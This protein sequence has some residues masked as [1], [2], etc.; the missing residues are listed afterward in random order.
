VV[1]HPVP[2]LVS[3]PFKLIETMS[4]FS[5]RHGYE[6]PEAEISVRHDAPEWL[7]DLIIDLAYE[8]AFKPSEL[9]SYLCRVLLESANPGN[10][11]EF[12]NIDGEVR[13]LLSAAPWFYVYDLIEW[14][15]AKRDSSGG[16]AWDLQSSATP[17]QFAETINRAFRRKGV[18]WQLVD[19]EIQVRGTEVFETFVREAARFIDAA[20]T[21]DGELAHLKTAETE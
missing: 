7:R 20:E 19:G 21:L 3:S 11:S 5:Q 8:A 6:P 4:T 12:P 1:G 2:S 15:Y 9:R 13:G 17:A 18:G 14:L 10:W 16:E